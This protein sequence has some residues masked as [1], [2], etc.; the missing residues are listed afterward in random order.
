MK[1]YEYKLHYLQLMNDKSK[2][3]QVLDALNRFGEEGWR[4]NR[5]YSEV[6]FRSLM[7]W[8]GGLN[9]ILERTSDSPDE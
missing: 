9:L 2:E 5:M 4:L 7:T 6:S 3:V 8:R 1:K